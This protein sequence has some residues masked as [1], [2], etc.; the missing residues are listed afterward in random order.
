MINI[1]QIYNCFSLR[2]LSTVMSLFLTAEF[3]GYFADT[4]IVESAS[5]LESSVYY[6][7]FGALFVAFG[8]LDIFYFAFEPAQFNI[9]IDSRQ[10]GASSFISAPPNFQT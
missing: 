9:V 3:A 4:Y 10:V 5:Q 2:R 8:I 7:C 1:L 6:Y